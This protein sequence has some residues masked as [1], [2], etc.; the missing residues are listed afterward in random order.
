MKCL[1]CHVALKFTQGELTLSRK[2][3]GPVSIAN[4]TWYECP[5]CGDKSYPDTTATAIDQAFHD[6]LTSLILG[7][8]FTELIEEKEVAEILGV[9]VQAVNKNRAIRGGLIWKAVRNHKTWYLR[10]SV[11][12]F[13]E[14]GDGRFSLVRRRSRRLALPHPHK[15]KIIN[16][17]HVPADDGV[18]AREG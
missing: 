1:K 15:L 10:K 12:R 13:K 2:H 7:R 18:I 6:K 8:P 3:L 17:P 16:G 14:T 9:S 11:E 5:K 4:S